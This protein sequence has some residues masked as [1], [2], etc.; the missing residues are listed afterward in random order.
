MPCPSTGLKNFC[1]GPNVLGQTKKCIVFSA[2][3]ILLCLDKNIIYEMEIIFWSATNF[4]ALNILGPVEGQ[5]IYEFLDDVKY[6]VLVASLKPLA[7]GLLSI[8][9]FVICKM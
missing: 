2:T 8:F 7:K 4:F 9:N 1:A 5:G 3:P 6:L